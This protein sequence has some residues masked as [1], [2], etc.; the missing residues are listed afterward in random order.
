[1]FINNISFCVEF[2]DFAEGHYCKDFSKRYTKKQWIETR[3]TII[4]TLER[5]YAF[6]QTSRIDNIKYS[7]EHRIG[8]FKLDFAVAGTN[9]SPKKSGNRVIF[10]LNNDTGAIVIL[11]V[12]GKDHCKKSQSETQW[13]ISQVKTN[14]PEYKFIR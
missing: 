5:A 8:I 12:Y 14:F 1:M 6:Q 3:K 7:Q 10:S 11:L 9:F 13:I 2:S 4:A